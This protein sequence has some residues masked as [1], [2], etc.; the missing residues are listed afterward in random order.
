MK[1]VTVYDK[2]GN[3]IVCWPD[4]ATKLQRFGYSVDEPKKGK[5]QKPKKSDI[6][7]TEVNEV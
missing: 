2:D 5:S 7:A 3:M 1:Q 6:V 4:T